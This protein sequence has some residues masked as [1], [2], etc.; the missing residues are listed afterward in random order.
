M[1]PELGPDSDIRRPH[2]AVVIDDSPSALRLVV[3]Y[4]GT[5]PNCQPMGFTDSARGL[6]WC[7]AHEVDLIIVDYDMPSPNGLAFIETFRRESSEAVPIVMVTSSAD[8]DVR[9]KALRSGATDFLTKPIDRIEFAARM[10]NL[11][12]FRRTHKALSDRSAWLA[13]AVREALAEEARGREKL[14]I[15]SMVIDQCPVSVIITDAKGTIEYVNAEFSAVTGYSWQE[16]VGQKP[17]L[18]KSGETLPAVYEELWSTILA[19]QTWRGTFRNRRKDGTL[20]WEAA[21]ISPIRNVDGAI[22]NFVAIKEDITLRREYEDR[23]AW[24][25]NYDALTGLPNRMLALDRLG[26]AIRQAQRQDR[27]VAVLLLDLTRFKKLQATLGPAAS[28]E[29]LK[30]AAERLKEAIPEFDTVARVGDDE[31][32]IVLSDIADP[33]E[34]GLFAARLCEHLAEPFSIDRAECFALASIGVTVYPKD[35]RSPLELLRNAYAAKQTVR[36][37]GHGG[38]HFFTSGI[39]TRAHR[40]LAIESRLRHALER[41]ELDVHYQPLLSLDTGKI[42]AAEALLRWNSPDLGPISPDQFIPVAEETGQICAIGSWVL[43]R[44]CHDRAEWNRA[45]LPAVRIAVN[46]SSRQLTEH[47]LA[48]TVTEILRNTGVSPHEL[49]L[50]VTERL[51]LDRSPKTLATLEALRAIGLRFAIDDFGTGYS[52]M[53]YLTAFPFDT[54]KIDRSFV[55]RV[56][57]RRPEAALTRA[58]VAMARSLDIDIIAEGI[59][60]VE[61]RDFLK[62][63][64]C[65]YGQGFLFS[66]PLPADEFAALLASGVTNV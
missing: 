44:A 61:Q 42:E 38:W 9:Y 2:I 52:A 47:P 26:Q 50:E 27:L 10:R 6:E 31:F 28:D 3:Q 13:E 55:A 34:P 54:L 46:V 37:K 60:T 40:R 18:F 11:L 45:G 25:A 8:R 49:E 17:S 57:E 20:F 33:E 16:A 41:N 53:S 4:L 43:E 24:Q 22:T 12:D 5:V 66:R 15:T 30:R 7:L 39:D 32:L 23:I 65:G 19:G 56:T 35:G 14:N 29:L 59:E 62:A 48:E 51:L 58:I 1:T 36:A 64:G 21:R 63:A